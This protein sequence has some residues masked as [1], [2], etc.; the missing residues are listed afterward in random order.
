MAFAGESS[1]EE[2]APTRQACLYIDRLFHY[3]CYRS[4]P[5]V[6]LLF[7]LTL[8]VFALH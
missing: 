3:A 2:V 5:H 4:L 8:K 6:V 7:D 1:C